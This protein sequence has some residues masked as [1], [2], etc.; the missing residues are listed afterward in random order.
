MGLFGKKKQS[1]SFSAA[2]AKTSIA[3]EMRMKETLGIQKLESM[4]VQAARAFQLASD[5][6]AT[7]ADFV[8]IIESDEALSA[9]IIRIANSVYF[10]RGEEVNDIAKAVAS[11]GLNEL[12]CLMSATMLRSLLQGKHSARE[13]IWANSVGTAICCRTLSRQTNLAEGEAFLAGL[14]H[15]VGKLIMIRK[16]A[17]QY[18]KV[19][20]IVSSGAK[21]FV[22]AEE[23]VFDFSHVDVGKWVA[24]KWNFPAPAVAAIAF[25]HGAWPQQPE[26]KG[27][28]TSHAILVKAC[29]VIS[30][31]CGIGHPP[32]FRPFRVRAEEEI[33]LAFEQLGLAGQ[34]HSGML[35]QFRKQFND[36]FAL[37]HVENV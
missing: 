10:R 15:D 14:L 37:Y 12:R 24:E 22:Q 28:G 34:D 33:H 1:S 6:K 9:R 25:H 11:I 13:Q 7:L 23:E 3:V 5:P 27:K 19:L 35:E 21:T 36:E 4:P 26:Q 29:D 20:S 32:V 16:S 2:L 18:D 30:H 31:A 8:K 17:K